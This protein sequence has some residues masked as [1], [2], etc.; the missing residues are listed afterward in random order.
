MA[1]FGFSE[2]SITGL[3][4]ENTENTKTVCSLIGCQDLANP[5]QVTQFFLFLMKSA[6]VEGRYFQ[7]EILDPQL[8]KI[9]ALRQRLYLLY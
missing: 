7:R 2:K 6:R 4:V 1:P 9:I 5:P 3:I 8:C